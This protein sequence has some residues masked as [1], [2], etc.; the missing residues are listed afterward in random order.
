MKRS[1]DASG[2]STVP[3]NKQK[4]TPRKQSLK[5][6]LGNSQAISLP[7]SNPLNTESVLSTSAPNVRQGTPS[8]ALLP[9]KLATLP[10]LVP[11]HCAPNMHESH[12]KDQSSICCKPG[13]S[14]FVSV[15][16]ELD[17]VVASAT[18]TEQPGSIT[19]SDVDF[20]KSLGDEPL[21]SPVK[22]R[23]FH[24]PHYR[25]PESLIAVESDSDSDTASD[26][27]FSTLIEEE[28]DEGSLTATS[29]EC[30]SPS[31]NS[32]HG[33]LDR[34]FID[35]SHTQSPSLKNALAPLLPSDDEGPHPSLQQIVDNDKKAN[36]RV[37]PKELDVAKD[38]GS[39]K[40]VSSSDTLKTSDSQLVV[41][42]S[43]PYHSV[44][45]HHGNPPK[46]PKKPPRRK[47]KF[48][49]CDSDIEKEEVS[50][51]VESNSTVSASSNAEELSPKWDMTDH[52]VKKP[53]IPPKPRSRHSTRRQP[54]LPPSLTPP[55]K[56]S[57]H[58][59]STVTTETV[60]S[61]TQPVALEAPSVLINQDRPHSRISQTSS[62]YVN[63]PSANSISK[64]FTLSFPTDSYSSY[65]YNWPET[66]DK[67][68]FSS[69]WSDPR[70]N[71]KMVPYCK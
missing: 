51:S 54:P 49:S 21:S 44:E 26:R 63:P 4:P 71:A 23:V 13:D 18:A 28:D 60:T 38:S 59:Q 42:E 52:S 29:P 66:S 3:E 14:G 2:K 9:E 15:E 62:L 12:E 43:Q 65:P 19:E 40:D 34:V 57:S 69:T 22:K 25:R 32:F 48:R 33:S 56:V 7:L 8:S 70:L 68:T 27:Y 47:N 35:E 16:K 30:I 20:E 61:R 67:R 53:K 41:S 17:S 11:I 6:H 55:P 50:S 31:Q 37:I 5:P 1:A 10:R 24:R 58:G 64:R 36:G 46:P 45:H 39:D